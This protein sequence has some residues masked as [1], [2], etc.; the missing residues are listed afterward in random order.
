M[1]RLVL[2]VT[3]I[4]TAG[5][6]PPA[7]QDGVAA[8]DAV[9]EDNDG[10]IYLE[11]TNGGGSPTDVTIVTSFTRD[12]LALADVVV[13][14]PNGATRLIGPFSPSTF[15]Q[16]NSQDVHVDFTTNDLDFRAY[17]L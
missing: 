3:P 13:T 6:A 17:R 2:T 9:I 10:R 1:A 14:V 4:T 15:N 16:P 11:V 5:V 7:A 12:G 8:D